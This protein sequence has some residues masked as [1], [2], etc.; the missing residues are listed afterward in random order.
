[1]D[2]KLRQVTGTARVSFS[3]SGLAALRA[4]DEQLRAYTSQQSRLQQLQEYVAEAWIIRTSDYTSV[5][6]TAPTNEVP[7]GSLTR[8]EAYSEEIGE[9]ERLNSATT[10]ELFF[11]EDQPY[12]Y[13]FISLGTQN[14]GV[15]LAVRMRA[16]YLV[17]LDLLRNRILWGSILAAATAIL[18]ALFLSRTVARPLERLSHVALR[19][20]RGRWDEPVGEGE[21]S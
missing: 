10:S 11:V 21:G 8:F 2:D 14:P 13:G 15:V 12:K 1:M 18:L 5:V 9:A 3:T 19:I 20:Q 7:I 4:G 17:P 6:S 16:D